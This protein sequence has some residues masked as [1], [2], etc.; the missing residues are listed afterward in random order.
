MIEAL[1]RKTRPISKDAFVVEV[2]FFPLF[3]FFFINFYYLKK[4]RLRMDKHRLHLGST[5]VVGSIPPDCYQ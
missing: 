1:H 2:Q 3:F 4:I 5:L